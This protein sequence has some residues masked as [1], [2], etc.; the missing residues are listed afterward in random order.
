MKKSTLTLP[1]RRYS[2][3][4]RTRIRSGLMFILPS[5]ILCALFMIWPLFEV[6]RYSFTDWNGVAKDFNYVWFQNYKEIAHI[7]G[8]KAMMIATVT[9]ALGTT[10]LTIIISFIIA[11]ALDKKGVL[12]YLLLS[13]GTIFCCIAAIPGSLY[14]VLYGCSAVALL[15]DGFTAKQGE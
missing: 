1:K 11:L 14:G 5:F 8:F 7:D 4:E 13:R 6:V 12:P 2:P 9:F 10:I 3:L 15:L